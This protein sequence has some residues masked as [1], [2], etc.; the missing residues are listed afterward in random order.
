V[1]AFRSLPEGPRDAA[2]VCGAAAV[3]ARSRPPRRISS[4][5]APFSSRLLRNRIAGGP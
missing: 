5:P 3:P 2:V 4:T 1:R